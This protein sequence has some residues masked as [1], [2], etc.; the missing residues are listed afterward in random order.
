MDKNQADTDENINGETCY[1]VTLVSTAPK[2]KIKKS[3]LSKFDVSAPY[4]WWELDANI[5]TSSKWME[6]E[7]TTLTWTTERSICTTI[8]S[9]SSNLTGIA[10]SSEKLDR[11]TAR[12][13]HTR[14]LSPTK[15]KFTM[16]SSSRAALSLLRHLLAQAHIALI[17]GKPK[18][19]PSLG[20]RSFHNFSNLLKELSLKFS[21]S[22][23]STSN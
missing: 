6:Q 3:Q 7:N 4:R 12:S 21:S 15:F 1:S 16:K 17:V 5:L 19:Q 9:Q 2:E 20:Q 10:S 8:L 14:L 11:L 18:D 13:S 22:P 23:R